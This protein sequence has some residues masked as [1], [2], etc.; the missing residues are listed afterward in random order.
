M[1]HM[2][3]ITNDA[4]VTN[5]I[6]VDDADEEQIRTALKAAAEMKDAGNQF[7]LEKNWSSAITAYKQALSCLPP[8]PAQLQLSE[9]ELPNEGASRTLD[10]QGQ[11][12]GD[13]V[14]NG[15]EEAAAAPSTEP[16][17]NE[18]EPNTNGETR[19]KEDVVSQNAKQ[20]P[21][22]K[23]CAS[24]RVTLYS[25]IAAC[26]LKQESWEAAVK[27]ATSALEE[28]PNHHK[29][30]W[31]RAKANEAIDS[32]SSLTSAQKDY[33]TIKDIVP[34]SQQL[35]RDAST[36]LR[37]IEPRIEAARKR[38]T[39]KMIGQLKEVGNS[40][41]GWFGLSTDNFK[42]TPNGEGGYSMNFVNNP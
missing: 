5:T 3:D 13:R 38:D 42:M 37:S 7:F 14:A 28:D 6:D 32:W 1:S 30:L 35:Y 11:L 19:Q 24:V 17:L 15:A 18:S 9:Q 25:N 34:P 12:G 8:K 33:Q 10:G 27:A 23:E 41:L 21:L 40:V 2:A 16:K 31:R 26:E 22:Q 29:A 4:S 20:T 36:V 39:E